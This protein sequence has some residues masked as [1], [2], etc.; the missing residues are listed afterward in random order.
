MATIKKILVTGA[1]GHIGSS[2]YL[3]LAEDPGSYDV[4]A[5]DRQ[6][7]FSG[8]VPQHNKRIELKTSIHIKEDE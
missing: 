3:K 7:E 6:R 8:R 1:T 5:L 2:T 4:Y